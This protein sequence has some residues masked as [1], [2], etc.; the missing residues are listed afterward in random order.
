MDTLKELFAQ[1]YEWFW[2][3]TLI[4]GL[5]LLAGFIWRTSS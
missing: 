2:D 5:T 3:L 1:N 4:L